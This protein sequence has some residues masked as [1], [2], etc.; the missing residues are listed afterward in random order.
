LTSSAKLLVL[1]IAGSLVTGCGCPFRAKPAEQ[2]LLVTLD[3][4][5]ADRL[6]CYGRARAET[7]TLDAFA[8]EGTLFENAVAPVPVTL[9]SHSC[10]MTGQNPYRHGVRYNMIHVLPPSATTLAE[11][12]RGAGFRTGAMPSAI[13]VASRFGLGQGFES[14]PDTFPAP[15]QDGELAERPAGEAVDGAIR[16]WTEHREEKRFF[17]LHLY[18]PHYPYVPP[19]PYS[20]TFAD[21]PYEGEIAS[22]DHELGRLFDALRKSGDW[23]RTLVVVAGDH[24]EGL[25]EHGERWHSEQV[26]DSTLHVPLLIK[27]PGASRTRRV[28]DPVGLVD[29]TPTILDYTGVAASGT[30]DGVSLRAAIDG[31]APTPRAV[32]FESTTGALNYGWSPLHGIRRGPMKYFEGGRPEMYDL[33][34]DPRELNDLAGHDQGAVQSDLHDQLAAFLGAA[35]AS[36]AQLAVPVLDDE[37]MAQLASLGYVGAPTAGTPAPGKGIHPPDMV[38]LEQEILRSQWAVAAKRWDEAA[39]TLDYVL[40]RDP[41]NRFALYFR[42]RTFAQMGKPAEA[43][44]TARVL[45]RLSPDSTPAVDL[46]GEL[47]SKSGKPREAAEHYAAALERNPKDTLLRYHRILVLVDARSLDAA[48]RDLEVLK[49]ERERHYSTAMAESLLEA[50]RGNAD[51]SLAALQRAADLGLKSLAPVESSPVFTVVRGL[52]GYRAL[53][54]RLAA[55]ANV[56]GVVHSGS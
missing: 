35:G 21:R 12:L 56:S 51:A 50:A 20:S 8:R 6:G 2:I 41:T 55:S 52:P 36:E 33:S 11:R 22:M 15:T 23:D 40:R 7:P 32:Y 25:Y 4:T 27:P 18:T 10:I 39:D 53:A 5:R 42:A 34:A 17:W 38:E 30:M 28:R 48:S 29:L 31:R 46:V 24:G 44:T 54:T 13:V 37:T 45:Q 1:S 9:P 14:Y 3:T 16:W 19:F 49:R 47:L 43:L 26:Y